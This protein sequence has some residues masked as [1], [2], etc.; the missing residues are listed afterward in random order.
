MK[1]LI[2]VLAICC[3]SVLFLGACACGSTSK[4]ESNNSSTTDY[5]QTSEDQNSVVAHD[6]TETQQTSSV[7]TDYREACK[8][9]DFVVAHGILDGLR[10]S[11]LDYGEWLTSQYK[12]YEEADLYIFKQECAYLLE[13]DLEGAEKMVIKLISETPF[14]GTRVDEGEYEGGRIYDNLAN[15][16][17]KESIYVHCINRYNKK[18]DYALEIANILQ[19]EELMDDLIGMY[20]ENIVFETTEKEKKLLG[21]QFGSDMRSVFGTNKVRYSC[22]SYDTRDRDAVI[23]KYNLGDK[24]NLSTPNLSTPK[25]NNPIT[26]QTTKIS[27]PLGKFFEIVPN[28]KGYKINKIDEKRF[29][30]TVELKRIKAGKIVGDYDYIIIIVSLLDDDNSVQFSK[31]ESLYASSELLSL[32]V[33]E[34]TY[35]SFDFYNYREKDITSI[36]HFKI[37]SRK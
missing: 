5:Q 14:D 29:G 9:L 34:S 27:G 13:S 12:E 26:L 35:F 24:Y 8:D 32:E 33:G 21:G 37:G 10:K 17:G 23:S 28:E 7:Q 19:K 30:F 4:K 6:P 20:K 11:A 18:C 16:R 22:I 25:Q 15:D 3:L 31:E 36:T 2:L 1:K